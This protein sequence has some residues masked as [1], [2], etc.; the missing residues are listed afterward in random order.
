MSRPRLPFTTARMRCQVC[1]LTQQSDPRIES[2]WYAVQ[3]AERRMYVCPACMGNVV[4]PR[5][6]TCQRYYHEQYAACPWCAR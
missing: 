1:G 4:T 5:C 6:A 3:A 2:G